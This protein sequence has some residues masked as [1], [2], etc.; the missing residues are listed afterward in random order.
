M[1]RT[2]NYSKTHLAGIEY[3]KKRIKN[4]VASIL[5]PFTKNR[6]F[7][8][9]RGLAKGFKIQAPFG[10][11]R[12]SLK[13]KYKCSSE[14][15]FLLDLNLKDKTIYDVGAHI[16]FISMFFS[17]KV[18][19]NG[20]LIA[21][22]PNPRSFSILRRNIELNQLYNVKIFNFGL[23][24]RKEK[25]NL[26]FNPHFSGTG[27]MDEGIQK[28]MMKE[29]NILETMTVKIDTIDNCIKTKNLLKPDMV[30]ID[31]EGMEYFVLLGMRETLSKYNPSLFIEIHGDTTENKIANIKRIVELIESYQYSIY[32]VESKSTISKSNYQIARGGHI[33]CTK[34]PEEFS[35]FSTF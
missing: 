2:T 34:T 23:G 15:L 11:L 21:F 13:F 1:K 29:D 3:L 20:Y 28:K 27:S 12:T 6:I 19:I 17:K 25:K 24:E 4:F 35:F 18:G 33:F 30:K 8:I 26:V 16:G 9:K 31:V 32:H 22:E 7:T 5:T 14:E 10:F